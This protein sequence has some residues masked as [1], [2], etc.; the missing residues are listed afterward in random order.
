MSDTVVVVVTPAASWSVDLFDG[1][2]TGRA[3][4]RVVDAAALQDVV[5]ETP[6][7]AMVVVP[8]ARALPALPSNTLGVVID[9]GD[10]GARARLERVLLAVA[11]DGLV[12]L[13]DGV[14]DR[15]QRVVS[16][17]GVSARLTD[18]EAR[19][20]AFLIDRPGVAASRETL[21]VEVWG[22]SPQNQT[23]TVS[24]T[25]RRLR[26]KIERD[27]SEP[28]HLRS[29]DG[30]YVFVGLDDT[31]AG[32]RPASRRPEPLIG[33]V[34]LLADVVARLGPG[35][36]IT[37]HG[38]PGVG[39]S[40]VAR[41]A[42]WHGS[43]A[44][45][46]FLEIALGGCETVYDLMHATARALDLTAP[47]PVDE[48]DA[49]AWLVEALARA[50]PPLVLFDGADAPDG[51]L[52]DL[53]GRITPSATGVISTTRQVPLSAS[54]ATVRVEPLA[55]HDGAALLGA[56]LRA[57]DEHI[58]T[59]RLQWVSERLEHLPL[60]LEHAARRIAQYGIE[61][62]SMRLAARAAAGGVGMTSVLDATLGL[63]TEQSRAAL[64][65]LATLRDTFDVPTASALLGTSADVF[66]V[67]HELARH[68]LLT[69][70]DDAG[71][72]RRLRLLNS[73]RQHVQLRWRDTPAQRAADLA[74][75]D[76]FIARARTWIRDGGDFA[77]M[78]AALPDLQAALDAS[79]GEDA[80]RLALVTARVH[81]R[82]GPLDG[83]LAAGARGIAALGDRPP[84]ALRAMLLTNKAFVQ[85]RLG[86]LGG[87]AHDAAHAA[88]VARASGDRGALLRALNLL[89]SIGRP[90]A[91]QRAALAEARSVAAALGDRDA[92]ATALLNEAA[93]A[94]SEGEHERAVALIDEGLAELPADGPGFTRQVALCNLA[95]CLG[96][97]G[98]M[99]DAEAALTRLH[100]EPGFTAELPLAHRATAV[101]AMLRH[102]AG[103]LDAALAGYDAAQAGALAVGD[104]A[105][106][107]QCDLALACLDVTEGELERALARLS[108][109][110]ASTDAPDDGAC[111]LAIRGVALERL[112]RG[113]EA[114]AAR[115]ASGALLP[116]A[117][118]RGRAML[119]A[120]GVSDTRFAPV[121]APVTWTR[122]IARM[123]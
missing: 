105:L 51:A 66:E 95:L 31:T 56:L 38:V 111:A 28:V 93:L 49:R 107:R 77:A 73:V 98:R 57:H 59:A 19:L 82:R 104:A 81:L 96:Y 18:L 41:A 13:Y 63:L 86:D 72:R 26:E 58:E 10:P 67:V 33:R 22:A 112:G 42:A 109:R 14:Y 60:A 106:A 99:A 90:V 69:L 97:A 29:Q 16:R 2:R 55:P 115:M 76:V 119:A 65:P 15:L 120:L 102:A 83:A 6:P 101:A 122:V 74:H 17:K 37:L 100:E 5:G 45:G 68:A 53:L 121:P 118:P 116:E 94:S 88:E 3:R 34:D 24:T 9:W 12:R 79:E 92:A 20:L 80:A 50:A 78:A 43:G 4:V 46:A 113:D 54:H 7:P 52:N 36:H 84:C 61:A 1:I 91:A 62:V 35:R 87:A 25:M 48:A 85:W 64:V 21:L 70:E 108:S 123:T 110:D 8:D 40:A 103:G 114:A 27:P 32:A 89:G 71:A 39:K 11:G 23:R 75:R 44:A 47:V 30:G 117:S